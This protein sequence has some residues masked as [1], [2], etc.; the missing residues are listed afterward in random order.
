METLW[1]NIGH[2]GQDRWLEE[3][4]KWGEELGPLTGHRL[5]KV[6][7]L[8]LQVQHDTRRPWQSNARVHLW[9]SVQD[10][11]NLLAEVPWFAN[12]WADFT[13]PLDNF[14]EGG[15]EAR[16]ELLARAYAILGLS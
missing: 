6:I 16:D 12:N 11:W 5:R 14:T 15:Y 1:S 2:L 10:Q 9:N 8:H 4:L 3:G 7:F 13:K